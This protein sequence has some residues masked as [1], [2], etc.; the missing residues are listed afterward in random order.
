MGVLKAAITAMA[1]LVLVT[2]A[3]AFIR[4]DKWWMRLCD[5]PRLQIAHVGLIL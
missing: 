1:I 2:T 3:L 4:T 5:F